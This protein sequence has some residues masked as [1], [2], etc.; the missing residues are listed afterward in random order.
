MCNGLVETIVSNQ[1]IKSILEFREFFITLADAEDKSLDTKPAL[2][3]IER[4]TGA[5]FGEKTLSRAGSEVIFGVWV[6]C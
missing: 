1:S 3:Y 5:A 2:E 4:S 6:P